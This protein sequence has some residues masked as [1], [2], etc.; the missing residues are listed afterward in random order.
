M[1]HSEVMLFERFVTICTQKN[2]ISIMSWYWVIRIT[3]TYTDKTASDVH[4]THTRYSLCSRGPSH[5]YR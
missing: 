3:S 1:G 2:S 4:S 5:G